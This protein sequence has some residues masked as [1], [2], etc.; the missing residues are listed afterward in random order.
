MAANPRRRSR[1]LLGAL[2][3]GSLAAPGGARAARDLSIEWPMFGGGPERTFFNEGETRITRSTV[4]NLVPKW[5]WP[6]QEPVTMSPAVATVEIDGAPTRLVIAGDYSGH[7]WALRASSGTPAWDFEVIA[8]SP[9]YQ[10]SRRQT[11][12]GVAIASPAVADVTLPGGSVEQRVFLTGNDTLYA[13]EAAT[14]ALRWKFRVGIYDP[15]YELESSPVVH[16]GRIY[17]GA[18]CNNRCDKSGI[19]AVDAAD[20]RLVWFW[21]PESG[22]AF[23]PTSETHEFDPS[24]FGPPG[25][26]GCGSIWSSPALD[27]E[28]G[29][30]IATTG[31][32]PRVPMPDFDEAVFA[33]DLEGNVVWRFRP[34][35]I[36]QRDMDFGATPNLFTLPGGR[37]VLGA[38][39]KDGAYYL[40]EAATGDLIWDTKLVLGGNFGGFYNGTTD[41]RRIYLTSGIGTASD[42]FEVHEEALRG[43]VFA[44]DVRT[45]NVE[46]RQDVGAPTVGQN[47]GVPGVYFTGGL[48]H[49]IHAYD[50][51]TGDLLWVAPVAGAS[52]STPV[53]VDGEIYVGSG[54]GATY[55]AAVG[56]CPVDPFGTPVGEQ[57][58]PHPIPITEYGMGISAFCLAT[59]PTCVAER[60]DVGLPRRAAAAAATTGQT[61]LVANGQR[62][63]AYDVDSGTVRPAVPATE[64]VNGQTC[65]IP[66]DPEGRFVQAADNPAVGGD[67]LPYWGVFGRDGSWTGV[68]IGVP[69]LEEPAGCAFDGAGNLFG[70]DVGGSHTP[71]AGNGRLVEFFAPDFVSSCLI[72]DALSQPG[73]VAFDH[74]NRLYVPEAGAAR[75]LRYSGL[76]EGDSDCRPPEKETFLDGFSQGILTPIAIVRA[77]TGG[78]A[79]SSVLAPAGVFHVNEVADGSGRV[80]GV[81]VAPSPVTGN[82]FGIGFDA[83][84]NLYYAD[85]GLGANTDPFDPIGPQDG[86]GALKTVPLDGPPVPRTILDGLDFPDGVTVIPASAIG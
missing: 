30:L 68:K 64:W 10:P 73:M 36:D 28:L 47:S 14:G 49:L 5:R 65:P 1:L 46:W 86:N 8:G 53:V 58:V 77:P 51:E 29:L 74:K 12:Y 42:L 34:R 19:F 3:L 17:F 55:R 54:T 72:D 61:V 52:S 44:L 33:L 66:G 21:D 38:P 39:G 7:Y 32:C 31:D 67:S 20:G 79:V 84:G 70:I 60:V 78:W 23:H 40:L 81:L 85:L 15:D 27:A 48:D 75:V 82:P 35:D 2:M 69:G 11:D 9:L 4:R 50:M 37:R 6:T 24:M 56:C 76:P 57:Q 71:F 41:G 45:G 80:T 16:G 43:R 26:E 83:A 13:L 62:L 18:Q 59:E 63:D 25:E 22:A